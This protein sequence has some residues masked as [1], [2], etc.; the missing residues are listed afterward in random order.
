[1]TARE[2][3]QLIAEEWDKN[4]RPTASL[5]GGYSLIVLRCWTCSE[6]AKAEG[7]SDIIRMYVRASEDAQSRDW[8]DAY[9]SDQET[10]KGCG[11]SY[12]FENVSICTA[13]H[14]K[15]CYRCSGNFGRAH[16]GNSACQCGNGEIVG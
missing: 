6:G 14:S 13:C 15:Y 3:Y 7:I 5:K 9:F 2:Q 8:L 11:E 1:M 4:G 16:N 10:C 12:R